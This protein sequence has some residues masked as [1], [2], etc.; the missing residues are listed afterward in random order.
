MAQCVT[1]DL[2]K[3]DEKFFA[4]FLFFDNSIMW[5]LHM[6]FGD[7]IISRHPRIG[8]TRKMNEPG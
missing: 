7:Y 6:N 2:L 5:V 1:A 8:Q 3:H 4:L